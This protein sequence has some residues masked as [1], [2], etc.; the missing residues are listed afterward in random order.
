MFSQ[1]VETC[2]NAAMFR[3]LATPVVIAL[4]WLLASCSTLVGTPAP[5]TPTPIDLS[6]LLAERRYT[7]AINLLEAA[8][9]DQPQA[10]APLNQIG[11]IYLQQHRWLPAQ[12]AFNRALARDADNP[13]AT[14]GLAETRL[15]Q[16]NRRQAMELWQA[17][18][19]QNP[20]LP[21]VFTGLGRTLL[22]RLEFDAAKTA[23]LSQMEH[24]PD[25]EAQ[26]YLAALDSTTR[27]SGGQPASAGHSP[28][29]PP[30]MCWPGE[31]ICWPPWCPS[32]S[33][34]HPMRLRKLWAYR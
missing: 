12:D 8:A 15:N 22:A 26:W 10:I 6:A 9:V 24:H 19:A 13:L 29:L 27:C 5:P 30:R 21:G 1:S 18:A 4:C 7:E 34:R 28:P 17:A 25:P 33:T 20:Q 11:Q 31:T 32:P 16:G 23:F 14:A 2:Y 3:L